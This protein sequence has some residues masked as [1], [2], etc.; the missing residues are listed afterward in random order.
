MANLLLFADNAS[1]TLA[2][3][4]SPSSTTL[5]VA[6]ATGALFSNPGAG[7]YAL[8]TLEDSSGNVEVVQIT[9]RTGDSFVIVR[10]QEGTSALTFASGTIFEQR[11]TAGML[12]SFLQKQGGDTLSGTTT[13]SGVLNLG[14]GGSIQGGEYAGGYIRSQP[15]DTSNQIHV[16]IGSPATAAGSVILTN[17]NVA[18]NLPSGYDFMHTGMI[19]LWSGVVGAIPAGWVLCNGANGTPDL[20]DQFIV[21]GGGSLPVTGGSNSL[22]TQ[23]TTL[24][25]LS[26]GAYALL[27]TDLPAHVH[28]FYIGGYGFYNSSSGGAG[29]LLTGGSPQTVFPSGAAPSGQ[30]I[31]G[32]AFG[33]AG[34]G[35]PA[36]PHTHSFSGTTT[37]T[38][39]YQYPQYTA[40][41]FIMKQ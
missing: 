23:P 25:G 40:V 36:N 41:F 13:V 24:S 7:Q 28:T 20:R 17:A 39:N 33:S 18:A 30:P 4:I 3:G 34:A 6:A 21:G 35:S 29:V 22:V 2:S 31:I 14:S 5:T 26:I 27:P 38:H 12:A 37:H 10:A 1:S 32:S 11:V 9:S 19:C 16:P 8:G 15:G